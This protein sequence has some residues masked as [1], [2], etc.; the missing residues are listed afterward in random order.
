MIEPARAQPRRSPTREMTGA[1][2]LVA[3]NYTYAEGDAP[4]VT[5][6]KA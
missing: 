2:L 5:E 1:E 6:T 4:E 3:S